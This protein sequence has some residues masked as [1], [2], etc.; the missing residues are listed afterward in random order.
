MDEYLAAY[1]SK[2]G[3]DSGGDYQDSNYHKKQYS[4][5]PTTAQIIL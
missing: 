3:G 5:Y 2:A 1:H 4:Y